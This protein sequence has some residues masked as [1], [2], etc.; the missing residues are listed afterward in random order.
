ML[1]GNFFYVFLDKAN[2]SVAMCNL[3]LFFPRRVI[4]FIAIVMDVFKNKSRRYFLFFSAILFYHFSNSG[5]RFVHS[6]VKVIC[7]KTNKET[8]K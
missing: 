5:L 8:N 4:I 6:F 7:K 1:K 3:Y 2:V